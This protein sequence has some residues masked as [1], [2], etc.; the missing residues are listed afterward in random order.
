M[1]TRT[2]RNIIEIQRKLASLPETSNPGNTDGGKD[3]S[4][5]HKDDTQS[6][7]SLLS[8][9]EPCCSKDTQCVSASDIPDRMCDLQVSGSPQPSQMSPTLS[10]PNLVPPVGIF[11]RFTN[12]LTR[13]PSFKR[14]QNSISRSSQVVVKRAESVRSIARNTNNNNS[15]AGSNDELVQNDSSVRS[16][17]TR[18]SPFRGSFQPNINPHGQPIDRASPT[19]RRSPFYASFHLSNYRKP[20]LPS[21]TARSWNGAERPRLR[22]DAGGKKGGV[23]RYSYMQ[24]IRDPDST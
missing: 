14:K 9:C 16:F 8:P 5:N 18:M 2:L 23:S 19:I 20:P 12:S 4:H 17:F 24:A 6:L 1:Y 22:S 13:P 21:E 11:G 15:I 3:N 10:M 7:Q